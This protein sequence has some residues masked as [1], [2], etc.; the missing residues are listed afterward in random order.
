LLLPSRRISSR[1]LIQQR[2]IHSTNPLERLNREVRRRTRVVGVF[3][4]RPSVYRLAGTL[5]LETDE[6][7]RA[8]RRYFCQESMRKMLGEEVD[9]THKDNELLVDAFIHLEV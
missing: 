9:G 1:L 5:L 6:D 2:S 8:E 3:P 4:D 7:W